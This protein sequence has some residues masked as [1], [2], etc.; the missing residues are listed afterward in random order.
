MPRREVVQQDRNLLVL[1]VAVLLLLGGAAI[2]LALS[3][4]GDTHVT[5]E[6]R[7]REIIRNQHFTDLIASG[8]TTKEELLAL[9]DIRPYGIGFVGLSGK[10]GSWDE[11]ESLATGVGATVLKLDPP[12]AAARPA[13]LAWLAEVTADLSG[14]TL[15][16][17]DH[18]ETKVVAAPVVNRVTTPDRPRRVLLHWEPTVTA[19]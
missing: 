13:L 4:K 3:T 5:R 17:L 19:P 8:K 7:I 2:Y 10:T 12:G 18:G 14:E 1:G 9:W 6:E 11:I 16:V 15:W